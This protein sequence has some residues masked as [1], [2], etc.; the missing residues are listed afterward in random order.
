MMSCF[1]RITD[2]PN[3]LY[4]VDDSSGL[5]EA[6]FAAKVPKY[7]WSTSEEAMKYGIEVKYGEGEGGGE[8]GEVA[9]LL[10]EL[11]FA[12]LTACR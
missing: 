11:L 1:A 12:T 8:G 10:K 2:S 5:S 4:S 9:A 3:S 6:R 7:F